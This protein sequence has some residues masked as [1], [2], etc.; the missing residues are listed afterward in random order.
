MLIR[1]EN[2]KDRPVDAA[3]AVAWL[4]GHEEDHPDLRKMG[5]RAKTGVNSFNRPLSLV[6]CS[7]CP[8]TLHL[9]LE[10]DR[11]MFE[12]FQTCLQHALRNEVFHGIS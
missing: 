10:G 9:T 11:S 12:L 2:P 7:T 8:H 5:A 3:S 6:E 4:I 1:S